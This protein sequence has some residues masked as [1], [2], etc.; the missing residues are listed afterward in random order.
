MFE[1]I[2]VHVDDTG[3]GRAR[4]EAAVDLAARFHA[5]LS[6]LYVAS[7]HHYF[8][9]VDPAPGSWE[10]CRQA[11][12]E[13]ADKAQQRFEAA[14]T[15]AG[16]ASEWRYVEG[17]ALTV[18][19]KFGRIVDLVVLGQPSEH[20]GPVTRD[21]AGKAPLATG[22]PT[23]L[24]PAAFSGT[25]GKRVLVA[26]NDSREAARAAHD[27]LL[28]LSQ[29]EQ[30]TVMVIN[31]PGEA[32]NGSLC[33]GMVEHLSRHGVKA[34]AIGATASG[35]SV[36]EVL[37]D[38]AARQKAD[39]IVMGGYGQPRLWEIALGGVTRHILK[40]ATVPVLMSH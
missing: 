40:Y 19:S 38:Q 28:V 8:S 35:N 7:L 16:I 3:S 15:R 4:L 26:W 13:E 18:I 6:G 34:E 9:Y 14:T 39:L 24:I 27:A 29:A 17:D 5:Y 23:L 33:A 22:R 31:R 30:V 36:G 20:A 2:L 10:S 12:R 25:L 37:L 21:I 1:D 11:L 32:Q